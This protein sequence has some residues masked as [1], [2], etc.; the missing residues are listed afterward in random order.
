MMQPGA[1]PDLTRLLLAWRNGDNQALD[2]LTPLVYGELRRIAASHLRRERRPSTL[3]PTALI[4]EAWLRLSQGEQPQWHSRAHFFAIASRLMRQILVDAARKGLAG[5]R[6]GG[7]RATLNPSI[8]VAPELE[9]EVLALDRALHALEALDERKC[10]AVELK[11][12]GGLTIAEIGEALGASVPTV[13]RDIRFA[14][15][16]LRKEMSPGHD[17]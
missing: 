5:K 16:W 13:V 9:V 14:E 15:A 11:Y 2:A 1:A 7:R 6:G 17:S 4:H 8:A 3:Q 10:R 12:F